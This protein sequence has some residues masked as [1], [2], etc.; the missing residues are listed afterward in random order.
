MRR[1]QKP[2]MGTGSLGQKQSRGKVVSQGT[3]PHWSRA[4]ALGRDMQ[5]AAGAASVVGWAG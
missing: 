2:W 4:Q 3:T 1:G 5:R